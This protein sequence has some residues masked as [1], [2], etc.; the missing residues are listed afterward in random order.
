MFFA[1]IAVLTVVGA[2]YCILAR[3]LRGAFASTSELILAAIPLGGALFASFAALGMLVLPTG[4][5]GVAAFVAVAS[6]GIWAGISLWRRGDGFVIPL[7]SGKPRAGA[8][9]FIGV[10][11]L[12]LLF[13]ALTVLSL[14]P[15]EDGSYTVGA[16]AAGD[17]FYHLSQVTRIA[18]T[19]NWDFEEPNFAGEFIGY[20]FFVNLLSAL[21]LNMGAPLVFA[22]HAPTL[23]LG[24]AGIFLF[25]V[26]LRRS[27]ASPY[28]TVIALMGTFF[29]SGLGY[30][31]YASGMPELG[32]LMRHTVPYPMQAIAYPAF[33]PTFLAV[34]R[35]FVFGLAL[36]LIAL[37]GIIRGIGRENRTAFLV[38]GVAIGL[39]P[40]SHTHSFIAIII[41]AAIG[42]V[43]CILGRD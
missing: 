6:G 17:V 20:P 29:G 27:G 10:S 15:S 1:S 30:V 4:A 36:F 16:G 11:V 9:L 42:L 39:L 34:Q 38:A 24:A 25:A 35:A 8:V 28:V 21:L 3:W 23:L 40:Q 7:A 22:F 33:I 32:L 2:A 12:V 13:G 43:Y 31:A 37:L 26:L 41:V 18:Y 5:A 19:T 14:A